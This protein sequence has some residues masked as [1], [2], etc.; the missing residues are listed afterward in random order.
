MVKRQAEVRVLSSLGHG[1]GR[2]G[3]R[4]VLSAAAASRSARRRSVFARIRSVSAFTCAK[5]AL[6]MPSALL[7]RS[8]ALCPTILRLD[9]FAR[10]LFVRS[11]LC[12]PLRSQPGRFVARG[13]SCRFV[14]TFGALCFS[15]GRFPETGFGPFSMMFS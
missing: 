10:R 5:A 12:E 6:L 7:S 1:V 9:I 4:F 2:P 11:L 15:G 3:S 14:L 8:S 13:L